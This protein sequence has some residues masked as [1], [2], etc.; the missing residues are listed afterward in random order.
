MFKSC[1]ALGVY[2]G[3]LRE[4]I[5]RLKYGGDVEVAGALGK[6]L[7][8][9][10]NEP[11]GYDGIV[12]APMH[13]ARRRRR[14]YDQARL[15][16]MEVSASLGLRPVPGGLV[17]VKNTASQ[18]SLDGIQ[19]RQ[20]LAG[21]FKVKFPEEVAGKKLILVDDV[22]TTGTTL[23]RCAEVLYSVGAK[24]VDAIVIATSPISN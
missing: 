13:P 20:N 1:R 5:L 22:M 15:L 19:R 3:D 8:L 7:R 23:N 14:G 24:D 16:A 9:L 2:E 17:R 18:T 4:A 10:V 6:A 11:G 12:W 21:A